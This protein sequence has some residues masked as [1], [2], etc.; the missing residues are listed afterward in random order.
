MKLTLKVVNAAGIV[1]AQSN[2]GDEAFL[3]YRAAYSEGDSIVV[4]TSQPGHIL[5][6]F[7]AGIQP[8][9]VFLAETSFTMPVPFGAKQKTYAP[10]AFLGDLH[11]I[12]AR[13][14]AAEEVSARRNLALNPFDDHA[15][16]SLFP[17]ASANVETRGEAVFAARNAID[18]EKANTD[19]GFWPYTSWGINRD[20]AAALT[21]NF[22]RPVLVDQLAIYLRAD[23]PHDAWWDKA[24]V[25]FSDGYTTSLALVK[26]GAAQLFEIEPRTVEWV[27]LHDLKKA[28]D[29]SPFPALTQIEVWGVDAAT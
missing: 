19:H 9:L 22:G 20:P 18:G 7:D 25:T 26:T 17:H 27:T 11:R 21:V 28:E 12:S 1:L 8:A 13:R 4:E 24:C 3:V 15:N 29:P 16:S 14:A 6:S 10:Q 5:L 2:S 23:F